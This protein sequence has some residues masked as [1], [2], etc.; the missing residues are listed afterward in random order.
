MTVI[1]KTFAGMGYHCHGPFCWQLPILQQVKIGVDAEMEKS[2]VLALTHVYGD[3]HLTR[4]IADDFE[5]LCAKG[6]E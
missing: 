3:K 6:V 5:V 1:A 2:R 4:H